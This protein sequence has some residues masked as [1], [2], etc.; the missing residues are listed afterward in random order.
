MFFKGSD[1]GQEVTDA[2]STL[3]TKIAAFK[4]GVDICSAERLSQVHQITTATHLDTKRGFA[5]E[6]SELAAIAPINSHAFR[7]AFG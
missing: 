3:D 4:E 1:Y 5:G 7:T 6:A 2:I